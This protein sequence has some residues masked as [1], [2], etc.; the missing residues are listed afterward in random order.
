VVLA[1]AHA[2][3]QS[4]AA[5]Q[6]QS[7]GDRFE[8]LRTI[9]VGGYDVELLSARVE[10]SGAFDTRPAQSGWTDSVHLRFYLP[11]DDKVFITVRQLRS[12][13]TYYWLSNVSKPFK[14]RESNEY[15]WPTEPVL[16]SLRDLRIDDLGAT[17][18]L[19]QAE[20]AKSERVLPAIMS[21]APA[22]TTAEAYRFVLKTN[23]RANVSAAVYSEEKVLYRRPSNWEEANSPFTVRWDSSSAREGWF[24][25]VLSGYF[26]NNTPLDKEILFYHRPDLGR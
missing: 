12:R 3:A 19:G 17:V 11:G 9:F 16:R 18:R 10:P 14:P 15:N 2:S 7:R 23:G 13:T 24:R 20:P 22:D 25:L 6:Y 8:G 1:L 5:L 4:E 21:D 26:A